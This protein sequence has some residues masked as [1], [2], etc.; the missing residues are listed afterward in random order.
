VYMVLGRAEELGCI[1][2]T[3]VR[4]VYTFIRNSAVPPLELPDAI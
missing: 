2:E 4:G 1:A 3:E